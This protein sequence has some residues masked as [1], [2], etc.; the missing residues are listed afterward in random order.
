MYKK[1]SLGIGCAILFGFSLTATAVTGSGYVSKTTANI[2]LAPRDNLLIATMSVN[3]DTRASD[4]LAVSWIAP[5]GSYCRSSRFVISRGNN[6]T[7]DVSWAYR[8][9][10][11]TGSNGQLIT[12]SGNWVADV[13]N[14]T[15]NQV[16]ASAGYTVV[17][18][19]NT[20]TANS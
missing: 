15:T 6:T 20:A 16:L 17:A 12:C 11:H 7:H 10:I 8:T 3:W 9:V 2:S 5:K 18:P 19:D 1:V 13:V 14:L 4:A